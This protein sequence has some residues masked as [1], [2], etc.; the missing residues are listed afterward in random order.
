MR[1]GDGWVEAG[2]EDLETSAVFGIDWLT[3][4]GQRVWG[5]IGRSGLVELTGFGLGIDA[6]RI[7]DGAWYASEASR[8]EAR[9]VPRYCHQGG[10]S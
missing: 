2:L 8:G 1:W 7:S 3:S 4:V 9:F 6:K 10:T 5:V